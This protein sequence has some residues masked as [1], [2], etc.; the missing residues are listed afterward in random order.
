ML[1]ILLNKLLPLLTFSILLLIPIGAQNA[2][3]A[4]EEPDLSTDD[5]CAVPPAP[6]LDFQYCDLSGVDLSN[7]D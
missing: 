4:H 2:F 5:H 6:T 1:L 7:T 3:A